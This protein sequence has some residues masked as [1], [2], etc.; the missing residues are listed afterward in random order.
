MTRDYVGEYVTRQLKKIVRPNQE[1][2]PNEAETM[3]LSCGYQELLRKVLLE[4]DLQAKN[5]G[6]RKVMAYH[7]EN[8]MDVVLEG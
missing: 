3:L 8:A 6:S 7:I 5:D 4:A 1:G 2:D